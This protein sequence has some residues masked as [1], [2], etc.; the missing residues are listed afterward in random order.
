MCILHGKGLNK[1]KYFRT[2]FFAV[3]YPLMYM[4]FLAEIG[5]HPYWHKYINMFVG[6]LKSYT[7]Y[8]V[9]Y[10][11]FLITFALSFFQMFPPSKEYP[12]SYELMILKVFAMLLGEIEL[13]NIPFSELAWIRCME[14]LFLFTFLIL[15][16]LVL[17]NLLNALAFKDT[18]D[19]LDAS[20]HDKLLIILE[21]ALFWGTIFFK[22]NWTRQTVLS[23]FKEKKIYFPIFHPKYKNNND[24]P[25]M[26]KYSEDSN[27]W[28]NFETVVV[29][30]EKDHRVHKIKRLKYERQYKI[31]KR[32]AENAKKI[33]SE[34]KTSHENESIEDI[35]K[36][37]Q[38]GLKLKFYHGK[39]I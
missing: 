12:D 19:M 26:G 29:I 13:M 33:I 22:H 36:V 30:K 8:L 38:I 4:E 31:T 9:V 3:T 28:T 2:H 1:M 39:V 21:L 17:Q 25:A 10:F 20:N 23:A 27:D 6:V 35:I 15:I 37:S 18:K 32:I 16:V 5:Y 34:R 7:W 11:F 24:F 14:M